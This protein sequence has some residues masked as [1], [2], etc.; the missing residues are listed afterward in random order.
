MPELMTF[1]YATT[2]SVSCLPID[3]INAFEF[4][5]TVVYAGNDRWAVRRLSRCYNAAGEPDWEPIPSDRTPEWL[6]EYRHDFDTA[7]EIARK[8]APT[9]RINGVG[10]REII[11][12][13][14]RRG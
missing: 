11:A 13:E 14:A 12:E 5:L 10:V 4:T 1:E 2:H 3:H 8:V 6:A 9:L 7:M